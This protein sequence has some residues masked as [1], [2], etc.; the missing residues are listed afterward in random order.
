MSWE[1]GTTGLTGSQL[2]Q[3]SELLTTLDYCFHFVLTS[4]SSIHAACVRVPVS[5]HCLDQ[6]QVVRASTGV[7]FYLQSFHFPPYIIASWMNSTLNCYRT[8]D[9]WSRWERCFKSHENFSPFWV[10]L[11]RLPGGPPQGLLHDVVRVSGGLEWDANWLEF[12]WIVKLT[13]YWL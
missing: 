1:I 7:D 12:E 3:M 4:S 8:F 11:Q 13:F 2:T 6:P 9:W 5:N 10:S